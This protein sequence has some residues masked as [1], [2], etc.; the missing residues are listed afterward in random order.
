MCEDTLIFDTVGCREE[1]GYILTCCAELLKLEISIKYMHSSAAAESNKIRRVSSRSSF[2]LST[3]TT[4]KLLEF[5][6]CEFQEEKKM[7][8]LMSGTRCFCCL[9]NTL[10]VKIRSTLY[11]EDNWWGKIAQLSSHS[12]PLISH[13]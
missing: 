8:N 11:N 2:V 3:T 1:D 9:V 10:P 13:R 4:L 12:S 7:L 6:S 5:E